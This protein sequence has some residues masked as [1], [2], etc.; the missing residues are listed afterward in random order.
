M[1]GY[2]RR[3]QYR[4]LQTCV[5]ELKPLSEKPEQLFQGSLNGQ[6]IFESLYA[7]RPLPEVVIEDDL[8]AAYILLCPRVAELLCKVPAA[9]KEWESLAWA[10]NY[11]RLDDLTNELRALF[12]KVDELKNL[13]E[14]QADEMLARVRRAVTQKIGLEMDITGLRGDQPYSGKLSEFFVHP[15]IQELHDREEQPRI[16]A[17]A[18]ESFA[19]F[20]RPGQRSIIIG[21]AGAG[22]STWTRWLQR[23]TLNSNWLGLGMRTELRAYTGKPLPSFYDLVREAAGKH[24]AE[25]LTTEVISRWVKPTTARVHFGWL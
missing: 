4:L 7:E 13:P 12:I 24:L 23:E 17:Q 2:R 10:E 16:L 1:K 9:I 20:S 18:A 14:H 11:R 3:K 25:E 22:K 19:E 6:K 15:A 8:K 5:D 21:A